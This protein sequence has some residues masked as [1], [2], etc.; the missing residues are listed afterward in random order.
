MNEKQETNELTS[1]N[2][3]IADSLNPKFSLYEIFKAI[4]EKKL[5]I[6]TCTSIFTIGSIIYALSLPNLYK[7]EAILIPSSATNEISGS[8]QQLS[9]LASLA[10]INLSSNNDTSNIASSIRKAQSFSF[11]SKQLSPK[12]SLPDLM[13]VKSWDPTTNLISFDEKIYDQA[14]NKWLNDLG[15]PPSLQ[16][17][18]QKFISNTRISRDQ[19]TGFITISV[20]H[21][22]PSIAKDWV[23][24]IVFEIN[25]SSRLNDK[26][27]ALKAI[28]Y[29][30]AQMEK[31]NYAELK[32]A[33]SELIKSRMQRLTLIEVNDFY[34]LEY[35][36]P[37]YIPENRFSPN[38]TFLCLIGFIAGFVLSIL[39]STYRLFLRAIFGN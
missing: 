13:A 14:N 34:I 17:A 4:L 5:L 27:E 32:V 8:L 19:L 30:N 25:E 11:F 15:R 9:G 29:L 28:E 1:G 7:S 10:G 6:F 23:E 22:S 2:Q 24:L 33:L 18:F 37:P 16:T 35:I 21:H 26:E 3:M 20:T 36:D 38:R 31:T 39:L 12:L